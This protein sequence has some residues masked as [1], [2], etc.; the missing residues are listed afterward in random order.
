LVVGNGQSAMPSLSP[1][2]IGG[3]D[4]TEKLDFVQA[5]A[6]AFRDCTQRIFRNMHRKPGLLT[7]KTI[8]AA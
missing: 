8:K 5:L 4:L 3:R 7:Q 2:A 6:R 1:L